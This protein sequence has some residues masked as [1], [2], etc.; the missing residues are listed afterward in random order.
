MRFASDDTMKT[1]FPSPPPPPS[2]SSWKVSEA[3]KEG[4]EFQ[5]LMPSYNFVSLRPVGSSS[6]EIDAFVWPVMRCLW[7][8]SVEGSVKSLTSVF[9][10]K[11]S[12]VGDAGLSDCE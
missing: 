2:P 11:Q 12:C 1:R 3:A 5:Q 6:L 8:A 4:M 7:G 10:I 9:L